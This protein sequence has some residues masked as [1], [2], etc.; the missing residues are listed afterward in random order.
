MLVEL[1]PRLAQLRLGQGQ[2]HQGLL[3]LV[4]MRQHRHQQAHPTVER[5][6]QDGPELRQED[7]RLG[8]AI[9]DR[10]HAQRRVRLDAPGAF[11]GAGGLVGAQVQAADGHR[12]SR[13][14]LDHG[15]IGLELL[16]LAG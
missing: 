6:A 3:D 16:V 11:H 14:R 12:L 10:A 2:H 8:Q 15:T 9:A 1:D 4:G 13:Q 7:M 5:S